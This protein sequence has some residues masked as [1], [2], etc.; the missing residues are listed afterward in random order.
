L[1]IF[2]ACSRAEQGYDPAMLENG[3]RGEAFERKHILT[4]M[5]AFGLSFTRT[6]NM[7]RGASPG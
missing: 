2:P 6:E 4:L 3:S 1:E 5:Q 7:G